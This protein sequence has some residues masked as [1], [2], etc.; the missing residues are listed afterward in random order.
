MKV[1]KTP[2]ESEVTVTMS[3]TEA[4][5]V[6]EYLGAAYRRM[7]YIPK[8]PRML[9]HW[10][11]RLGQIREETEPPKP[12]THHCPPGRAVYYI[13]TPSGPSP[14]RKLYCAERC[15]DYIYYPPAAHAPVI[16]EGKIRGCVVDSCRL[17]GCRITN[18]SFVS[19]GPVEINPA[20]KPDVCQCNRPEWYKRRDTLVCAACGKEVPQ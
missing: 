17:V 8:A 1:T 14:H 9:E 5:E 11:V 2:T 19:N 10:L 4:R 12:D 16:R 13:Q 20:P 3:G 7:R 15:P 18:C 6:G